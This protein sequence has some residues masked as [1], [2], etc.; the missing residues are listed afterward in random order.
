MIESCRVI[1]AA[2]EQVFAVLADGWNYA[3][4][5]VGAAHT[6]DVD[7]TWPAVGAALHHRVGPWP[8]HI[9]DATRVRAVVPDRM[10]ELDAQLWPIGAARIRLELE[11]L[12]PARTRVRMAEKL[13]SGVGR[14]MP[15]GLQALIL[16]PRNNEALQ[17]LEDIAVNRYPPRQ[18]SDP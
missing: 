13:L 10:L 11:P 14:L 9:E 2:P 16:R 12:G 1:D 5:V 8:L 17:R 18:P 15:H 3:N 6:R 7:S 4:W